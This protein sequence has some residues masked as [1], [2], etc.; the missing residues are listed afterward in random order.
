M[1]LC[2]FNPC[3]G[4]ERLEISLFDD[5]C[6]EIGCFIPDFKDAYTKDKRT[7][8]F[9]AIIAEHPEGILY[10]YNDI[11]PLSGSRGYILVDGDEIV[12]KFILWRS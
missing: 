12:S 8:E 4:Y 11:I 2:D 1:K 5:M 3:K 6:E 7:K 10:K 9:V